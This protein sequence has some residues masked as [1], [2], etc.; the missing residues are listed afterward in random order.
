MVSLLAA[1]ALPTQHED[2]RLMANT[3]SAGRAAEARFRAVVTPHV[4]FV[5]RSLR[6]LGIGAADLD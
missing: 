1:L 6:R 5:W 3:P 4:E 2:L